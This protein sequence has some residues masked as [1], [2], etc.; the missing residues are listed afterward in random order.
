MQAL[1]MV[2]SCRGPR[3]CFGAGDPITHV[4]FMLRRVRLV[5]TPRVSA[6]TCARDVTIV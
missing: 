2:T 3:V 4:R 5:L 6:L 1:D